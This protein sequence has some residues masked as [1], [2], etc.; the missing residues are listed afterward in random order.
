[1]KNTSVFLLTCLRILVGWHFLYE[2]IS[3]VISGSWSSAP[4]LAGSK[5]VFAPLF[6]WMA[7]NNNMVEI[8][9]FL[10]LWG[11]I[12]AGLGLML[13]LVTR[14]A[15]AGGALMLFFYFIAYPP[16]PGY[17]FGVPAE[18]NYLWV[19]RNLIEFFVLTTF[20]FISPGYMFGLDRLYSRWREEKARKPV[21][22]QVEAGTGGFN[23]RTVIKNLISLPA[24]G[25]FAYALYRKKNGIALRRSS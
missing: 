25:A 24:L 6:T 16:I 19:N 14:W 8:V 1:M 12:L 21:P 15:S 20:V 5:W 17:M 2:G 11:M 18:G 7:G 22:E 23:R 9:D 13:G 3:K 4:F 10:N